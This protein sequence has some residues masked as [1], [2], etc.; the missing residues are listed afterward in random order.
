MEGFNLVLEDEKTVNLDV[1]KK[2]YLSEERGQELFK[3]FRKSLID[4]DDDILDALKICIDEAKHPNEI[5]LISI[6]AGQVMFQHGMRQMMFPHTEG[7]N[8]G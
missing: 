6:V 3:M 7:G 1:F 8:H 5:V 4:C 2:L